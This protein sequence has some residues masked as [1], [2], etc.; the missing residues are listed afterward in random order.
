[1]SDYKVSHLV[2][3]LGGVDIQGDSNL[4]QPTPG[5]QPDETPCIKVS[6]RPNY[7]ACTPETVCRK[8]CYRIDV[9]ADVDIG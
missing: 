4:S 3:D 2:A 6:Q 8:T 9:Q 1:M 7:A 5:L